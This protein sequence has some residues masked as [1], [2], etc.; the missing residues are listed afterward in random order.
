MSLVATKKRRTGE[1]PM[2]ARAHA[3]QTVCDEFLRRTRPS[4]GGVAYEQRCVAVLHGDDE[5]HHPGPWVELP[6]ANEVF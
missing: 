5:R 6:D 4:A 1:K 3:K 2:A